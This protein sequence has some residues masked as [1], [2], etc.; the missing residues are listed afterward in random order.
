MRSESLYFRATGELRQA[1][2][3]YSAN[4]GVT[5]SAALGALVERGLEAVSN[6][7]SVRRIQAELEQRRGELAGAQLKLAQAEGQ[8][9]LLQERDVKWQL[10]HKSI[11]QQ[12]RAAP[13][14]QCKHC[15][16]QMS[17]YDVVIAKKCGKCAK[18]VNEPS[19]SPEVSGW[20]ALIAGI[21]ILLAMAGSQKPGQ[22]PVTLP[23]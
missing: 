16:Q 21:G 15:R 9:N 12:L 5:L 6:E 18:S 23:R 7:E 3:E 14:G 13:G 22:L 8:V 17:A 11:E 20:V 10:F 4:Q 19:Q 2:D 1:V